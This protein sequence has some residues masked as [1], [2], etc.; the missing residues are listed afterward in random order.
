MALLRKDGKYLVSLTDETG[1]TGK[2]VEE[3]YGLWLFETVDTNSTIN[4][5]G[6][7]YVQVPCYFFVNPMQV[8]MAK[9]LYSGDECD[10]YWVISDNTYDFEKKPTK[11]K[12]TKW[13][14]DN[15]KDITLYDSEEDCRK[16]Q[17][18]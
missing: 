7:S 8:V 11:V 3:R 9:E 10:T 2:F 17:E 1:F 5:G 12:L 16:S 4:E 15:I 18:N 14:R 13:Q 6:S